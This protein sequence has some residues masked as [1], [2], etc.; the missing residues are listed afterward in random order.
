MELQ[1]RLN[2]DMS[3]AWGKRNDMFGVLSG[4]YALLLRSASILLSS[5][6]SGGQ[7][8][9]TSEI[10][11]AAK[12]CLIAPAA[13]EGQ[14]GISFPRLT[15]VPILQRLPASRQSLVDTSEFGLSIYSDFFSHYVNTIAESTLPLS[16]RRWEK[17][18]EDDLKIRRDQLNAALMAEQQ[19][20]A[21]FNRR[22][23]A[24]V[25]PASVDLMLRP[26]CLDDMISLASTLCSLGPDYSR[27]FWSTDA[28]QDI[29]PSRFLLEVERMQR[30]DDS[31]LASYVSFLASL[32]SDS[33]SASAVHE[34][35]SR[36]PEISADGAATSAPLNWT[37]L[38]HNLRW[39]AQE[40]SPYD[41]DAVSKPASSS[42]TTSSTR[43]SDYYYNL[44]GQDVPSSY[45]TS[46]VTTYTPGQASS[47]STRSKAKELSTSANFRVASHLAVI[48]NVAL[49]SAVAQYGVLSTSIPIGDGV[50][51]GK[52]EALLVLFKLAIAPLSPQLRGATL[53]T[54][55]SLLRPLDLEDKEKQTFFHEQATNAWAY[56]EACP[57][58]PI[59]LLDQYNISNGNFAAENVGLGF[60]PSSISLVS[61]CESLL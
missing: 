57:L 12:Y 20:G 51:V 41:N 4:S 3:K 8:D 11:S 35:L 60:P 1:L 44:D 10:R 32:S 9:L 13:E 24:D 43:N 21:P 53:S 6:R 31:L 48:M 19:F 22:A 17:S 27:K 5:P 61:M 58:L 34:L 50:A 25:V 59:A 18:E 42:T 15:L 7:N 36:R 39:Y 29:Q 38:L 54:I 2:P 52:D 37:T 16:R 49:H 40:L 46:S 14:N 33:R 55:S 26:D 56:L 30:K 45:T 47:T 28:N 23:Q